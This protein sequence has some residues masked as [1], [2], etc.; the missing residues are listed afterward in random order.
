MLGCSGS[1]VRYTTKGSL[2]S[3]PQGGLPGLLG[4]SFLGV[5]SLLEVLHLRRERS[6]WVWLRRGP[7]REV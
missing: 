6:S 1:S 5:S 3:H 7:L 4:T 2:G